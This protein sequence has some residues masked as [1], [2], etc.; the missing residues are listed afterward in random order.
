MR[1]LDLSHNGITHVGMIELCA[2]LGSSLVTA[3]SVEGNPVGDEGV[4]ALYNVL[5]TVGAFG[6]GKQRGG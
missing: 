3:L 6:M 5:S 2:A 4:R 1:T